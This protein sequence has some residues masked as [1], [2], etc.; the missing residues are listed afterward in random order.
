[1]K[2]DQFTIDTLYDTY[3]EFYQSYLM[4]LENLKA[5]YAENGGSVNDFAWLVFQKI[6][7]AL[8]KSFQNGKITDEYFYEKSRGVYGEM[9]LFQ[10]RYENKKGNH[11]YKQFLLND[12]LWNKAKSKKYRLNTIVISLKGCCEYC[13]T[14][15]EKSV[16]I[17]EAIKKQPLDAIKCTNSYGCRACYGYSIQDE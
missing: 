4:E 3:R 11:T 6:L 12:L 8:A 14:Q 2:K 16:P 9:T 5:V 13:D 10:R 1:M 15:D 17:E 7:E